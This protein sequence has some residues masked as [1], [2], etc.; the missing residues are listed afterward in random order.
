[1]AK[2]I[3]SYVCSECGY[4]TQKWMGRCPG[5]NSWNTLT[6]EIR[7]NGKT[8]PGLKEGGTVHAVKLSEVRQTTK[9]GT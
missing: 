6:E 3:H 7:T 5:C 8:V 4:E 9:Y 1:M 2:I